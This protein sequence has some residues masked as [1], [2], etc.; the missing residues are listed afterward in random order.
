MSDTR[1]PDFMSRLEQA[2]LNL[3]KHQRDIFLAH[4]V[5]AMTYEEIGRRTGLSPR[6]VE[7]QMATAICRIARQID[8]ERLRWWE[9]LF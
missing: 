1:D 5:H 8:G 4:R 9:R 3:P 7:R 6:Q 2:I